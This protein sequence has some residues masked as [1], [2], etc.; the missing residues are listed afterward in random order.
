[1]SSLLDEV[2][3]E[4]E[5]RRKAN[6][7]NNQD[8]MANGT[9]VKPQE[10]DQSSVK[11]LGM[12]TTASCEGGK[13]WS[14]PDSPV[15]PT[16]PPQASEPIEPPQEIYLEGSLPAQSHLLV[17]DSATEAQKTSSEEDPAVVLAGKMTLSV[18]SLDSSETQAVSVPK[19]AK[20]PE[21][22]VYGDLL[23]Q[24]ENELR[25]LDSANIV[26]KLEVNQV[27]DLP[28][29]KEKLSK[30]AEDLSEAG[31]DFLDKEV[32]ENELQ[33]TEINKSVIK[34]VVETG[35]TNLE[36]PVDGNEEALD[37]NVEPLLGNVDPKVTIGLNSTQSK[38]EKLIE[39]DKQGLQEEIITDIV[40]ANKDDNEINLDNTEKSALKTS[41]SEEEPIEL[42]K[43]G[44]QEEIITDIGTTNKD[45][46]EI[47]LENTEKA[48]LKTNVAEVQDERDAKA[49]DVNITEQDKIDLEKNVDLLLLD[50]QLRSDTATNKS[51]QDSVENSLLENNVPSPKLE[52]NDEVT[53][54]IRE[55]MQKEGI[56]LE[57]QNNEEITPL[58][59]GGTLE[60]QPDTELKV[61][62]DDPVGAIQKQTVGVIEDSDIEDSIMAV[63]QGLTRPET[64]I[65]TEKLSESEPEVADP[66]EK[67]TIENASKPAK[68]NNIT[69]SVG[70]ND[71]IQKTQDEKETFDR[72]NAAISDLSAEL[73]SENS[74]VRDRFVPIEAPNDA[75]EE[76]DEEVE[77]EEYEESD[78]EEVDEEIRNVDRLGN[79]TDQVAVEQVNGDDQEQS[80]YAS[81]SSATMA[82]NEIS[83]EE[84]SQNENEDEDEEVE[85]EEIIEY[86]TDDEEEEAQDDGVHP[87]ERNNVNHL[88]PD[89]PL[90]SQSVILLKRPNGAPGLNLIRAPGISVQKAVLSN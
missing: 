37:E 55:L 69:E 57:K 26:T 10:E 1:M 74:E 35:T 30:T 79:L 15:L 63:I 25:I 12:E 59:K 11:V 22:K 47:N 67:E 87:A 32:I 72:L 86:I 65:I 52:E 20:E 90:A 85:I 83:D 66:S 2:D 8:V 44:L 88:L 48:A 19:D 9:A 43:R 14:R 62:R 84:N 18:I 21:T 76:E 68:D 40:I 28:N 16:T 50:E 56:S 41:A 75:E 78:N 5:A 58:E 33:K 24:L 61:L 38:V 13:R 64:E 49:T 53:E 27:D 34:E 51:E 89:R 81:T 7:V 36:E 80:K 77:Y 60:R 6:E 70:E 73:R 3:Q 82:E 42:G 46:N 29:I 31:K 45:N 71:A 39:L 23:E 4:I 54:R 17:A